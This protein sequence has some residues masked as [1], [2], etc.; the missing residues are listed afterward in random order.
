MSTL[1]RYAVRIAVALACCIVFM[2]AFDAATNGT[3]AFGHAVLDGRF[4]V[5]WMSATTAGAAIWWRA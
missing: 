5:M 4:W 3:E 1:A 2:I